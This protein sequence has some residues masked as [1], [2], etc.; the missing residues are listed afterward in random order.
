MYK[1]WALIARDEE[2]DRETH[3]LLFFSGSFNAASSLVNMFR[4]L[5]S[6]A[7]ASTALAYVKILDPSDYA[8][9]AAD[10]ADDS[11]EADYEI[12]PVLYQ[13]NAIEGPYYFSDTEETI[14]HETLTVDQNDTSVIVVTEG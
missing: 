11:I 2:T 13:V 14:S 6:A 8:D 5:L 9:L 12:T 10:A 7:L 4:S 3:R 1:C